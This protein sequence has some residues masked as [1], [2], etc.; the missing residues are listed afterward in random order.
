MFPKPD[1]G[2]GPSARW[3]KSWL[4]AHQN[5]QVWLRQRF[6]TAQTLV[7]E[8]IEHSLVLLQQ[9]QYAGRVYR[10][11]RRARGPPG[12]REDYV[13]VAERQRSLIAGRQMKEIRR[14]IPVYAMRPQ[15]VSQ[16]SGIGGDIAGDQTQPSFQ[17][18]G[19]E[20][21]HHHGSR[22][23]TEQTIRIDAVGQ[24]RQGW[25]GP[26]IHEYRQR[27]PGRIVR[28]EDGCDG[29]HSPRA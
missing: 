3:S 28:P 8:G 13:L 27:R 16:S 11:K 7:P 20:G 15:D 25:R 12:G 10:P 21:A 6:R 9:I 5:A 2:S 19:G 18:A 17:P 23:A 22:N 24:D 26:L 1:N 4:R 14:A 29:A